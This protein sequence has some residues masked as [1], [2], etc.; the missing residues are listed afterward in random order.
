MNFRTVL[1]VCGLAF[2]AGPLWAADGDADDDYPLNKGWK[3]GE[4]SLPAAPREAD[5]QAFDVGAAA[6]NRFFVDLSS[7]S[8]GGDGVV[9]YVLVVLTA[10][11]ARN[12]SFEGMR[13][14]SRERRIYATG[15]SDGTWAKSRVDAWQRIRDEASKAHYATL[16]IN[17]FCP[18]GMVVRDVDEA[19]D[20]LRRGGHPSTQHW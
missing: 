19:R 20:A 17:Y 7:L 8:V 11:G 6:T 18:D 4:V 1:L 12:V 9:R 14:E 2:A 16:F 10:G 15:R 13:C 5:L 3:E